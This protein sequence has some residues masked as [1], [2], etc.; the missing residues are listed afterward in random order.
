MSEIELQQLA[1]A[2]AD[3][4]S[5]CAKEVLTL[6]EVSRYTGLKA[7]YIYQLTSKRQIPHYKPTGKY[8][9]FNRA[10][11]EEWLQKHRV[12]TSEELETKAVTFCNKKKGGA[13]L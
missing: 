1:E 3:R 4:A 8:I 6:E 5:L 7:S 10:E 11:V 12:S 9:F 2:I 13:S